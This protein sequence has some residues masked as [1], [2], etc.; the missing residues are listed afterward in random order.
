MKII[1]IGA[2]AAA[3]VAVSAAPATSLA[4]EGRGKHHH[5]KKGHPHGG[6]PGQ[7]KKM[8]RWS[9]GD[10]LPRAYY[11]SRTYY[12]YEPARYNLPPAPYG[13]RYVRVGDDVYLAQTQ[14]GLIAQVITN[15]L[16]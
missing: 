16:R 7:I 9:R 15:L 1:I 2:V 4:H 13:Y 12:I 6:P 5:V 10:H 11:T 8:R 3:M 14:T